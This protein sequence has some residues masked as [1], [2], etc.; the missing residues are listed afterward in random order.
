M[1][2]ITISP[3]GAARLD[4]ELSPR[5][6]ASADGHL[7]WCPVCQARRAE[8]I[9]R[10]DASSAYQDEHAGDRTVSPSRTI[11]GG[12]ERNRSTRAADRAA[13]ALFGTR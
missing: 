8:S 11:A 7:A 4:H 2:T 10:P 12:A 5:R 1:T 6:Q 13:L 3:T 9:E